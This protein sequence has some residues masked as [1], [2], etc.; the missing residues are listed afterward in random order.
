MYLEFNACV[1]GHIFNCADGIGAYYLLLA[2]S[3]SIG[4]EEV[5]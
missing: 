4:L 3:S 5:I 2:T 1:V